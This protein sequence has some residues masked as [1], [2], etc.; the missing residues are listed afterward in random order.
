[1]RSSRSTKRQA[2]WRARSVPIVVLPEPIK[3]ARQRIGTR[4]CGPRK[5]GVVVTRWSREKLVALQNANCTTVGGE[6]DF[7]EALSNGAKEPLAALHG[8]EASADKI[9]IKENISRSGEETD[10]G[11]RRLQNLSAT[12]DGLEIQFAGALRADK[13][14]FRGPDNNVAGDFLQVNITGDAF[15]GHVAHDLLD[16]N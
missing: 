11:K 14:A 5:G 16:I 13:R 15:Q 6:F 3:P 10:V 4:A 2:S 12:A 9:P 8:I 7:R 1:M